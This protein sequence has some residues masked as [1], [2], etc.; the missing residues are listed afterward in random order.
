MEAQTP[1]IN[2]LIA[3]FGDRHALAKAF[4]MTTE[5]I[6][7]WGKDGIPL[8]RALDIEEAT[9]GAI[10]AE[11]IISEARTAREA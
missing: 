7:L 9:G 10:K 2:R 1:L 3:H 5:G 6:R 8:S 11:E 4:D